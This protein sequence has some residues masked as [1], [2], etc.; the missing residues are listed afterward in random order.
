MPYLLFRYHMMVDR[1]GILVE[2]YLTSGL[3]L[4]FKFGNRHTYLHRNQVSCRISSNHFKLLNE[5]PL[6]QDEQGDYNINLWVVMFA[7]RVVRRVIGVVSARIV[8]RTT[9]GLPLNKPWKIR[10]MWESYLDHVRHR[11][12]TSI[13]TFEVISFLPYLILVVITVLYLDVVC[14]MLHYSLQLWSYG[15]LMVQKCLF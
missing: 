2:V 6:V 12:L 5:L 3:V 11:K 7:D 4:L 9:M 1:V 8:V 14:P 13:S 15:Q 10:R